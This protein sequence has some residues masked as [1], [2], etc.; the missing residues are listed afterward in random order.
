[1][2]QASR[3]TTHAR[4]GEPRLAVGEQPRGEPGAARRRRDVELVDLVAAGDA[5]AERRA[6]RPGHAQRVPE[7]AQAAEEALGGAER[8]Q[9]RRHEAVVG[10][11]PACLPQPGE[12]RELVRRRPRA[13]GHA[14]LPPTVRPPIRI[15]GRPTPT[16]THWPFLPQLPMPGSS[17]MSLPI[18]RIWRSAVAPSPISVAPLTGAPTTP[19][20]HPVGLGAGEDELAVGDVDLAAAEADGVDAVLQL[21]EDVGRRRRRRRACRC[22]SSAASARGRSSGAGRCRSAR[23]PSAGRSAGPACSRRGCRPRSAWC[24]PTGVPSSSKLIEPRRSGMV[25]SSTTVTPGAAMR[26]P[27]S[28]AKAEVPLRLKSPSSPWPIASC[29]RMPGQPGPST[30]SITPAGAGSA[31]RLTVGD[32]ERLARHALPVVGPH[33]RREAGS[34]R[35]RRPSPTRAGRSPRR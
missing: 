23:R 14:A 19:V 24:G 12:R 13:A 18:A 25:P 2:A 4:G 22:W 8:D 9:R 11:V 34:V 6:R 10:V 3:P 5:E 29:S 33:Q 28:P 1:M 32:P 31:S 17:A 20:L 16:G 35:R 15:V 7:V 30:T 21:G 26:L 27:I